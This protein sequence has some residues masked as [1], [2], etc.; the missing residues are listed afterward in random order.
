[1]AFSAQLLIDSNGTDGYGWSP[2][3]H[4]VVGGV[5]RCSAHRADYL[6]RNASGASGETG[7]GTAVAFIAQ[8]RLGH[9][10]GTEAVMA[11][12][13]QTV[14]P[15]KACCY[16]C[17]ASS[18]D[19]LRCCYAARYIFLRYTKTYD[20]VVRCSLLIVCGA[21]VNKGEVLVDVEQRVNSSLYY[22]KSVRVSFYTQWRGGALARRLLTSRSIS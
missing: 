4:R 14:P 16:A 2:G 7:R 8:S 1:M 5:V 10:V 18:H 6:C 12:D 11:R 15:V 22:S 21:K 3:R 20:S 13:T 9:R 17:I 19:D